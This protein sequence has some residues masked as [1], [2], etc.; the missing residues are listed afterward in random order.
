[1][2]GADA[3]TE[4]VN[5]IKF[6]YEHG[7]YVRVGNDINDS[8]DLVYNIDLPSRL[9][10]FEIEYGY[11]RTHQIFSIAAIVD[12][13]SCETVDYDEPHPNL[14]D[15]CVSTTNDF[16]VRQFFTFNEVATTVWYE[17]C[18]VYCHL[19]SINIYG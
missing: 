6:F 5:Y 14:Y 8:S 10:G 15:M 2:F 17:E 7:D 19:D 18:P 4:S 12:V 13:S 16:D 11:V 3:D 1:M 9:I